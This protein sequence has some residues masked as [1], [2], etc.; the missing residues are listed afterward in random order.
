MFTYQGSKSIASEGSNAVLAHWLTGPLRTMS[1]SGKQKLD[2]CWSKLSPT[3][4]FRSTY[5]HNRHPSILHLKQLRP[6]SL[7]LLFSVPSLITTCV[8]YNTA[9]LQQLFIASG[10]ALLLSSRQKF[11]VEMQIMKLWRKSTRKPWKLSGSS[12]S[13]WAIM[14]WLFRPCLSL[15]FLSIHFAK[16]R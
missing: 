16:Y 2:W 5:K 14:T 10:K 9:A 12:L 11:G 1:F 6:S 4:S 3:T 8:N 13:S 7:N 15:C